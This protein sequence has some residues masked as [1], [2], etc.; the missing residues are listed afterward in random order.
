MSESL[1]KNRSS[2]HGNLP[3]FVDYEN[4]SFFQTLLQN[5]RSL[6]PIRISAAATPWLCDRQSAAGQSGEEHAI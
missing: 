2:S 6:K 1:S 3:I 4:Q 5:R